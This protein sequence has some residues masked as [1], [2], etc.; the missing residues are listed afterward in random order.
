MNKNLNRT[1]YVN[2]DFLPERDAK[3]SIFDRGFLM[4]DAVYEYTAVIDGKLIEFDAHIERLRRSLGELQMNCPIKRDGFLAMHRALIAQNDIDI[5]GVYVQISRGVADRNFAFPTGLVPTV[6][7][8]TQTLNFLDN[9]INDIGLKVISVEDGR[10][11]RRDIK[12]VQLLYTAMAKTQ[13]IERGANDAFFV[14]DGFVT[15]A[16]A[17][18]AFIVK[19]GRII[20]RALSSDILHGVTRKAILA[21]CVARGL[22]IEERAFTIAEAQAADEVF[23]TASPF[24]ALPVIEV[25]G[26]MVGDGLP[27]NMTRELRSLVI[28][29]ARANSI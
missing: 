28:S 14:K 4:A 13:A 1:V 11:S 9:P 24:Y 20:T 18:N 29:E 6:I 12:S 19:D 2:G 27:G 8:F 17:A 22:A 10:W 23:V 21:L 26:K 3:V 5:G 16:T 25:D 7:A 15:E